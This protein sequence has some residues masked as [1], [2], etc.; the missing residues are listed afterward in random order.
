MARR[1][2]AGLSSRF[3]Q[4][5]PFNEKQIERVR[6]DKPVVYE[7]L[8]GAGTNLYTGTAQR[9]RVQERLKEH[10]NDQD[11]P[12]ATR[13]RIKPMPSIT[14]ARAEEKKIIRRERP[15]LNKT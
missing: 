3:G 10:L 14:E 1:P 4:P 13:F 9:G 8:T 12:G 15:K 7:G 5:R 11:L 6:D 2:R